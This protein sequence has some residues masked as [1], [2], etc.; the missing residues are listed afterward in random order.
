MGED[1][2]AHDLAEELAK[3]GQDSLDLLSLREAA[4]LEIELGRPSHAESILL[5]PSDRRYQS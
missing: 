1:G 5:R 4:I 2:E 3:S